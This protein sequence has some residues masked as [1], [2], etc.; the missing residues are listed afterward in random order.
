MALDYDAILSTT[1]KNYTPKLEDNVFNARPLTNWLKTKDRIQRKSGGVKIVVPIIY[2]ENSTV[3]SYSLYDNIPTTPQEGITAAEYS[4]KQY[5]GS[6]AIAGLEEAQN[7]G[8]EE[9]IDLLESKIM[10]AEESMQ[11]G[12][13]AMFY[14]DGTGN[15]SKDWNGLAHIVESGNT[16]GGIDSG[17]YTWWV[18]QEENTAEPLT[19][20]KMSSMWN[21][22]HGGTND[23]PNFVITTDTLWEKYES[24]LQPQLRYSDPKTADA[25]FVNLLYKGAPIVFDVDC[26]SGVVYFL[27]SKYV[28]LV[29]HTAN[30]FKN[31]PFVRPTG[32]DARYSQIIC[33]GNLVTSSRRRLGKLTAKTA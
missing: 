8:E 10:Q 7:N 30:W 22:C 5:A 2:G 18:S 27:N 15:S 11:E 20:A 3:G 32:Q 21:D 29:V 17:T 24:L 25:G 26:T 9:V 23:V 4:W 16:V 31:T 14:A 28:K 12:F 19:L 6:V 33:Y 13:N 1:L